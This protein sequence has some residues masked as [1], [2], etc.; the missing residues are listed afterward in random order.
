MKKF[1]L[2]FVIFITLILLCTTSCK[3]KD[4]KNN[5]DD[6]QDSALS[7]LPMNCWLTDSIILSDLP[8]DINLL[9][10][11][12][13]ESGILSDYAIKNN[14]KVKLGKT[15]YFVN[16]VYCDTALELDAEIDTNITLLAGDRVLHNNAAAP[17]YSSRLLRV[18]GE[19]NAWYDTSNEVFTLHKDQGDS[20]LQYANVIKFAVVTE[21]YTYDAGTL[22]YDFKIDTDTDIETKYFNSTRIN[23]LEASEKQYSVNVDSLT[24]GYLTE[25]EYNYGDFSDSAIKQEASV[26]DGVGYMVVD[27]KYSALNDNDGD[28]RFGIVLSAIGRGKLDITI[29]DAPTSGVSEVESLNATVLRADFSVPAKAGESKS[30]RMIVRLMSLSGGIVPFTVIPVGDDNTELTGDPLYNSQRI[31]T[32][33]ARVIYTLNEDGKS[34]T[35]SRVS[36]DISGKFVIPDILSDGLPVT[37]IGNDAFIG[38]SEITGIVIP[39]GIV[40]IGEGAFYGCKI[41]GITIPDSVVTLGKGA[42]NGCC[43]LSEITIGKSVTVIGEGAFFSCLGLTSIIIPDSVTS[44]GDRAF[45][46]C[47]GLTSV[48]IG[49]SVTAIGDRAFEGCNKLVEVINHSALDIIAGSED[50]GYVGYY[51]KEVHTGESKIVNNNSY[52]FYTHD[53]VNYLL[54][55]IG[56]GKEL[57]LP[58]NCNGE[59]Y[60][61]YTKAFFFNYNI[62]SVIIPD[63]VTIIG[64]SAF[65]Q[66]SSLTTIVIPD[67][68]TSIGEEAFR[69]CDSLTDV[70][71]SDIAKWSSVS[72]GNIYATPF[73]NAHKLYLNDNLVTELVIPEGV[74][75]IGDYAFYNC[76]LI[77]SVTMP[78][79]VTSIGD[80]AFYDG[81]SLTSVTL[82]SSITS[83]GDYAFY[84]CLRLT[85]ITIPYGVTIIGDSAFSEC[86]S[87]T[88]IVIPD[89]VTS[90]GEKA[91]YLCDNLTSV[92]IPDSVASIGDYAF[93]GCSQ[94]ENIYYKGTKAEWDMISISYHNVEL[95]RATRYYYSETQPTTDGYY[96]HYGDNGEIVVW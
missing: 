1:R 24:V 16:L 44:I 21:F 92:I 6:K 72:F 81:L 86:S 34:Y 63:S 59:N 12:G 77:T 8:D 42:F 75:S 90:I 22:Y 26:I 83:I 89:G 65:S 49:N 27:F 87:L 58:E 36:R 66:C 93:S 79:S 5:E 55:Y 95:L 64:D 38:C 78:S 17:S 10:G 31:D 68:I 43:N 67:S 69:W 13:G 39:V 23:E 37:E 61:I 9:F 80:Y 57:T 60:R 28:R 73:C 7:A 20:E 33:E 41:T 82:S 50:N 91:F 71:I 48:T 94:L 74:T 56:N 29:E 2:I 47:S 76:H 25:S 46:S 18:S 40:S 51:A 4:N 52:L 19:Y 14:G 32:G 30:V 53:G 54:G 45:S 3:D 62:T 84:N 15:A 85:S 70:Y 35:L 96:W 11:E 88:T